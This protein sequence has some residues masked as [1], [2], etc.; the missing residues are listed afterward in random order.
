[1]NPFVRSIG[2][3]SVDAFHH[4]AEPTVKDEQQGCC[5]S[6]HDDEDHEEAEQVIQEKYQTD[7]QTWN[8]QGDILRMRV[9]VIYFFQ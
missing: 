5:S 1:M 4:F 9:A 8:K 3:G 7:L 6:A 2:W